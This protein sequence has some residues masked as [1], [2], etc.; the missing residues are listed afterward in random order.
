MSFL[1][2]LYNPASCNKLHLDTFRSATESSSLL[3]KVQILLLLADQDETWSSQQ[4]RRCGLTV[5]YSN[6]FDGSTLLTRC[7]SQ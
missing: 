6:F 2:K 1:V 4:R 5:F 7:K 3:W